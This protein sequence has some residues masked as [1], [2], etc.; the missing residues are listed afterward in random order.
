[1]FMPPLATTWHDLH[2]PEDLLRQL[3]WLG[4][5]NALGWASVAVL[6]LAPLSCFLFMAMGPEYVLS[7]VGL[8][9]MLAGLF[10]PI[11]AGAM[12]L[13]RRG[14]RLTRFSV[15]LMQLAAKRGWYFRMRPVYPA[16][17]SCLGQF[18]LLH[19]TVQP[20]A[21]AWQPKSP[22][23]IAYTLRLDKGMATVWILPDGLVQTPCF[24]LE[25][26]TVYTVGQ[27][28]KLAGREAFSRAFHLAAPLRDIPTVQRLFQD[29]LL[30]DWFREQ[31][32]IAAESRDGSLLVLQLGPLDEAAFEQ[33]EQRL[34]TLCVLLNREALGR[35]NALEDGGDALPGTDAH[36]GQSQ[37]S[38]ARD[39]VV[40]QRR[41]DPRPGGP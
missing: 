24:M 14:R 20:G 36:G 33:G 34:R 4:I 29:D 5:Y 9:V 11:G 3:R 10:L 16:Q 6:L 40:N 15:A 41:R 32:K 39:H 25:P 19:S 30:L 7:P 1:M 22:G 27:G 31:G 28:V 8:G 17:T 23:V 35:S 26:R 18:Q 21:I 12:L 13:F 37:G 2:Q 38:P